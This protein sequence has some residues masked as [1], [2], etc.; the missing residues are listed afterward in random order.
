MTMTSEEAKKMF[1]TFND[2]VKT[3]LKKVAKDF[4]KNM[5]LVVEMYNENLNTP[6]I[7]TQADPEAQAVRSVRGMFASEFQ[8]PTA[9]YQIIV[10]GIE[11]SREIPNK[12]KTV[13][14][15]AEGKEIPLP[16]KHIATVRGLATQTEVKNS[17]VRFARVSFWDDDSTAPALETLVENK[18]YEVSLSGGIKDEAFNLIGTKMTDFKL[19]TN[20]PEEMSKPLSLLEKTFE[21]VDLCEITSRVGKGMVLIRGTLTDATVKPAKKDGK[22]FGI[23][24]IIDDSMDREEIQRLGGGLSIFASPE[25]IKYAKLSE[26]MMIGLVTNSEERG[27]SFRPEII[28]PIMAKPYVAP[29]PEVATAV[30]AP[31][32]EQKDLKDEDFM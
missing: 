8:R 19:V 21:H 6:V 14:K 2:T 24:R 31:P 12:D 26:V 25:Q 11:K 27:L 3:A 10:L 20:V 29:V 23:M 5:E 4:G 30:E 9:M 7:R 28:V 16:K 17:A 32:K 13:K 1:G 15:D 18:M 22:L